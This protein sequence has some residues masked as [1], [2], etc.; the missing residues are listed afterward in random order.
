MFFNIVVYY[1]VVLFWM[2]TW[3]IHLI[4]FYLF[5]VLWEHKFDPLDF[6][7][8]IHLVKSNPKATKGNVFFALFHSAGYFS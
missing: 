3:L 4:I 5:C 1:S 2:T 6:S 8:F 7:Q